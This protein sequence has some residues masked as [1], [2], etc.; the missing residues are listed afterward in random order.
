M[1]TF[2]F[3][4][5]WLQLT[6]IGLCIFGIVIAF[7]GA[8]LFPPLPIEHETY[9]EMFLQESVRNNAIIGSVYALAGTLM[10]FVF[11]YALPKKEKWVFNAVLIGFFVWFAINSGY[12]F[13]FG[14]YIKV[15]I[16][17]IYL[18]TV[19]VPMLLIKKQFR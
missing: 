7:F 14:I 6:A 16:N 5:R 10:F 4:V 2:N 18:L 1:R 12:H 11:T 15:V 9:A 8:A 19:F 3:C 13:Y 17:T